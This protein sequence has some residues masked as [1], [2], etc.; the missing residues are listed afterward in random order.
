MFRGRALPRAG[1]E[2]VDIDNAALSRSPQRWR[3]VGPLPTPAVSLVDGGGHVQ[4]GKSPMKNYEV[5]KS[6]ADSL[7]N[8]L[9]MH[10]IDHSDNLV[11]GKFSDFDFSLSVSYGALG[12]CLE[13]PCILH[14]KRGSGHGLLH[15]CDDTFARSLT[16]CGSGTKEELQTISSE[17]IVS[18]RPHD[19]SDSERCLPS[20]AFTLLLWLLTSCFLVGPGDIPY[21][22]RARLFALHLL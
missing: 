19:S 1:G 21:R 8:I 14:A 3:H 20:Q 6:I 15:F 22:P 4:Q 13:E 2:T 9:S 11:L 17:G 7:K 10:K 12:A 5:S 18:E 16:D